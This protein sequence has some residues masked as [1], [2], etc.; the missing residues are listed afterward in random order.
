[1]PTPKKLA[2]T[3][4]LTER[5]GKASAIYLADYQ[6]MSVAKMTELRGKLRKVDA[7]MKVVKNNL[8]RISLKETDWAAAGEELHGPSAITLA[9][10]EA[11][12]VAK[13]LKNFAK[14]NK[15]RPVVKAIGFDGA[16]HPAEF[17]GTL[18]SMPTREE[19]LGMLAG[20]FNSII[21]SSARVFNAL[22]DKMEEAGVESAGALAG[23]AKAEEAAPAA[24]EAPAAQAAPAEETAEA[25]AAEEAPE[26]DAEKKD[27]EA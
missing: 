19:A 13:I 26:A 18:A 20:V 12:A 24:E 1:M 14:D 27:D 21:A 2:I 6:G 9:Y 11:P 15:D 3:Q 22:K 23:G 25:P 4:D 10:G 17:L 7:E 8:I 16:V 5:L